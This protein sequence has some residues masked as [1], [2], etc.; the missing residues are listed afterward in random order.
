MS[1]TRT[2]EDVPWTVERGEQLRAAARRDFSIAQRLAISDTA[3]AD[4]HARLALANARSAFDW[5][6]D[7]DL[8]DRAHDE[9][10]RYGRWVRE[11]LAEGCSLNWTGTGY[12][13]RCPVSLAH[14]RF[15][16]SIG[17]TGDRIC[18]LCGD[19]VSECKH[20]PGE[21]YDVDGGEIGDRC[22]V[23][24]EPDCSEHIPGVSYRASCTVIVTT[25][26][27][28]EISLVRRPK[29]PE[30][31]LTAIPMSSAALRSAL[32]PQFK[33]GMRVSC[34]QCLSPCAGFSE[35]PGGDHVESYLPEVARKQGDG[36]F[37]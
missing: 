31:R 1:R 32:G 12:E 33:P 3:A 4:A 14:R 20:L 5:L 2:R 24:A 13:Q 25:G 27:I 29:Q 8:A 16:F 6:E 30:A 26:R 28:H 18:S 36:A 23:C 17:F 21:W 19:D 10:H 34:D 35:L 7:T 22:R 15:G 37:A 11:N 9:L